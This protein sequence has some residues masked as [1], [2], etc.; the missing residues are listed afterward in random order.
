[1]RGFSKKKNVIVCL[2]KLG[3]L[4]ILYDV[5]LVFFRTLMI[6]PDLVA[7]F[8]TSEIKTRGK[9]G[10]IPLGKKVIK[11][12]RKNFMFRYTSRVVYKD[13]FTKFDKVEGSII[14]ILPIKRIFR[15]RLKHLT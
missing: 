5:A 15:A 4:E 11:V 7:Q 9:Q 13:C 10:N 3:H 2:V 8:S 12:T 14:Q 1:M 6:E